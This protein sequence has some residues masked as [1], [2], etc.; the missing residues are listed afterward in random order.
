MAEGLQTF[1]EYLANKPR[2]SI[3]TI[4]IGDNYKNVTRDSIDRLKASM[5]EEMRLDND[6]QVDSVLIDVRE[7]HEG[8]LIDGYHQLQAIKE[9]FDEGKWPFV[10]DGKPQVFV[11]YANPANNKHKKM[12]ALKR[13]TEYDKASKEAVLEWGMDLIGTEFELYNIPI[14]LENADITLLDVMDDLGPTDKDKNTDAEDKSVKQKEIVCPN[15]GEA[16]LV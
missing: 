7:S 16:I 15:C 14:N 5:L 13:N 10:K 8:E 4:K 9:L 1:K 12:L 6:P 11:T 2:V 3:D